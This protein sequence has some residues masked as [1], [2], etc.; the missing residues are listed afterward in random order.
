MKNNY[1][2]KQHY[3]V[4]LENEQLRERI[5]ELIADFNEL[6]KMY[7]EKNNRLE[8]RM[9]QDDGSNATIQK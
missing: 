9:V 5:K 1:V 3:I 7:E 8:E 2:I 4:Q 6:K